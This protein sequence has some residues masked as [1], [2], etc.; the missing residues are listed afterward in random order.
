MQKTVSV[1]LLSSLLAAGCASTTEASSV[2][3]KCIPK[4]EQIKKAGRHWTVFAGNLPNKNGQACGWVMNFPVR[5]TAVSKALSECRA[6]E[7]DHPTWGKSGSCRVIY[8]K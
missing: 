6:S 4:F 5:E 8:I 3:G 2:A 1:F 7:R